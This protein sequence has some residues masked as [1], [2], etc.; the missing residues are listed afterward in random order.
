MKRKQHLHQEDEYRK[1]H[2]MRTTEEP[3][4]RRTPPSSTSRAEHGQTP[5]EQTTCHREQRDKQKAREEARKYSQT[6]LTPKPKIRVTKTAALATQP[7]PARQSDSHQSG[8]ES[9][10]RDDRHRKETQQPHATSR[11]SR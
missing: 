1:S 10:S 5:S 4:T 6:T 2:K 3:S 7:P 8:H 11:D 9:H